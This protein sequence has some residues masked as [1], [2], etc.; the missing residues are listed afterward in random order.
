MQNNTV[1]NIAELGSCL[2]YRKK[3]F[4]ISDDEDYRRPKVQ[5]A[6][7]GIVLRDEVKGSQIV[8]KEQ[9]SVR[10]GDFLVAEI[11]AKVGGFGI[12]PAFLDGSIVSSHYFT[13]EIDTQKMVPGY[14]QLLCQTGFITKQIGEHVRGSLNYAAVRPRHIQS[15]EIPLPSLEEQSRLGVLLAQ[16]EKARVLVEHQLEAIKQLPAAYLRE[17]FSST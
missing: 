8:T 11:D 3:F 17:A 16:T 12:V 1:L 9:Q 7:R 6:A 4:T 13:F 10:A 14:L 15:L 5:V 2:R